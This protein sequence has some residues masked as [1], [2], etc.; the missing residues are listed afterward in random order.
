MHH[1]ESETLQGK[2][3]RSDP[4]CA[5]SDEW[6][7]EMEAMEAIYGSEAVVIENRR[8]QIRLDD[9]RTVLD[10]RLSL[11]GDYPAKP[12]CIALRQV[13]KLTCFAF[14][15]GCDANSGPCIAA[16]QG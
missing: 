7:E 9:G 16:I 8:L 10:L 14:K 2:V 15:C 3:L 6:T 5:P 13:F 4:A 11:P 12:P 1:S